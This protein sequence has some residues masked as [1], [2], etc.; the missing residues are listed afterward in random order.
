M[1]LFPPR[2]KESQGEEMILGEGNG[3]G[4]RG[5]SSQAGGLDFISLP[6]EEMASDRVQGLSE[7]LF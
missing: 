4:C 3:D 2:M 1:E 6:E 5:A 7:P